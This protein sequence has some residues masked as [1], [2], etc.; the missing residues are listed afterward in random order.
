MNKKKIR[1]IAV[2][3]GILIIPLLYSFFY[4]KAFWDPYQT[5]SDVKVAVVNNDKGYNINGKER[6]LGDE[7]AKTLE[8]TKDLDFNITNSKNAKDGLYGTKYYA[9]LTIPKDFS[10]KISQFGNIDIPKITYSPNEKKNYLAAQIL[11]TA[12]SK[13]EKQATEKLTKEVVGKIKDEIKSVP[14]SLGEIENGLNTLTN[15]SI[16]INS[17][18]NSLYYGTNNLN[19][20]Y[21][22]FNNG[23]N[24]FT[25]GVNEYTNNIDTLNK[26]TNE[27]KKGTE[28]L[29][30]KTSNLS[31]L[32][33]KSTEL[34][35]KIEELNNY[36]GTYTSSVTSYINTTESVTDNLNTIVFSK[37]LDGDKIEYVLSS[38]D[39][40]NY[41]TQLKTL[42]YLKTNSNILI[43]KGTELANGVN[44]FKNNSSLL[45]KQLTELSSLQA[46][47]A[48]L[49]TNAGKLN[50]GV[51]TLNGN[52]K[53][54]ANSSNTLNTY[55]N[56]I[57]SGINSVNEGVKTLSN[58]TKELV[59]GNVTAVNKVDKGKN[60]SE[61]K[62]SK[63]NN[64][65]K[66]ASK[67]IEIKKKSVEPVSNYGTSFSPYFMSLSLWVGAIIIFFGIYFDTESTFKI[68]SRYSDKPK[69]RAL[70]YYVLGILQAL[71]L[72][73]IIRYI[74]GL[75]VNHLGYY[76]LSVILVSLVFVSIVQFCIVYLKDI[77]KFLTIFL[78]IIQLTSCGGTFPMETVP[79]F[80]NILYP[81]MPMTYSV[82]LFKETISGVENLAIG[83]DITIL[84]CIFAVMAVIT[85][86]FDLIKK[87]FKK[88]GK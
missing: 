48:L 83:T 49:D 74:L 27:F 15:G 59:N 69:V 7:L 22:K 46:A 40:N 72:G 5:L 4:L 10:K 58:G 85:I 29:K 57:N 18:V 38:E 32:S 51:A 39:Y 34:G 79:K 63:M 45:L 23:I 25:N 62:I 75:E 19:N 53:I 55:S 67:P 86:F 31:A 56:T 80:F 24:L 3:I 1:K 30:A 47:I 33:E 68:L 87:W 64:I 52:G 26:K 73:F 44:D 50:D 21:N 70:M 2:I 77:G 28:N 14:I 12:I 71:V 11:N 65:D 9:T 76:Y 16:K 81:Y 66:F 17:G 84:I 82:K 54:L 42:N 20:E 78:L 35:T 61:E 37:K 8:N 13:I 43:N 6:N 36:V 60:E 88:T 41:T